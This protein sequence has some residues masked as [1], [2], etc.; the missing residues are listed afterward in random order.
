M[1]R[2]DDFARAWADFTASGGRSTGSDESGQGQVFPNWGEDDP[3]AELRRRFGIDPRIT[4]TQIQQY[5]RQNDLP[6]PADNQSTWNSLGGFG[7]T[8]A[9]F[10][11]IGLGGPLGGSIAAA[12]TSGATSSLFG[13]DAAK[14]LGLGNMAYGAYNS[15]PGS[16]PSDAVAGAV[17]APNTDYFNNTYAANN[18][19]TM[20]D[21]INGASPAGEP[22]M[23]D[24][25]DSIDTGGGFDPGAQGMWN[26]PTPGMGDAGA[27][28]QTG[29]LTGATDGSFNPTADTIFGGTSSNPFGDTNL[30]DTLKKYGSKGLEA[31]K[32]LLGRSGGNASTGSSSPGG[33][34]AGRGILDTILG[35]PLQAAFN[36]APFLLALNESNKQSGDLNGVLN[37]INGEAYTKSVLNPYDMETGTGRYAMQNDQ[38]LRGVSGSSFGDQSLNNYDYTRSL[39]RSDMATKAQLAAA[40]LQGSLINTRNTNKNL[41]LGAGLS[42]SGSLFKPQQDPFNLKQL[43]GMA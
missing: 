37:S 5:F 26:A 38:A 10:A 30:L 27:F 28:D 23:W 22:G 18:T 17:N 13:N 15:G 8:L 24:W 29:S 32:L 21:A 6:G 14:A 25:L 16:T 7:K 41:L 3:T 9:G 39:G 43:F 4:D 2:Y 31:A 33:K 19:G 12:N 20:T 35:D 1:A 36:S 34:T 40:G 11:G 42:A